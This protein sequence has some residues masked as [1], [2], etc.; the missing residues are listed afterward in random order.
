[1]T[2]PAFQVFVSVRAFAAAAALLA[3][4]VALVSCGDA[5]EEVG[6]DAQPSATVSP[7]PSASPIL[8]TATPAATATEPPVDWVQ[9]TDKDLEFSL[10]HPARL[11][12]KDVSSTTGPNS[13]WVIDFRDPADAGYAISV[14]IVENREGLSL[15]EWT[16]ANVCDPAGPE[17]GGQPINIAGTQGLFCWM[18][19]MDDMSDRHVVFEVG[20]RMFDLQSTEKVSDADF[21]R[22]VQS[23]SV[24][25]GAQR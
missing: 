22:A 5:Q 25:S 1:M 6:P 15:A 7:S 9:Y 16:K 18:E 20:S 8:L 14:V 13:Q 12:P 24:I 23:F 3:V 19:V 10:S 11:V 17:K 21:D 4:S 2:R